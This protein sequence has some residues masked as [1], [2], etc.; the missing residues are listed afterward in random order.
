MIPPITAR[1]T[2]AF[3][4]HVDSTFLTLIPA[5]GNDDDDDDDDGRPPV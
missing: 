2:A 5:L 3:R 4:A 1:A